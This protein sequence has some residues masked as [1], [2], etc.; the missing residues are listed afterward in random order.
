MT[1]IAGSG[2]ISRRHVSADPD[3]DPHQNVMDPEHWL[4]EMVSWALELKFPERELPASSIFQLTRPLSPPPPPSRFCVCLATKSTCPF[5]PTVFHLI[6]RLRKAE[7]ARRRPI[8]LLYNPWFF[9]PFCPIKWRT[10]SF[11][12]FLISV[13]NI[14]QYTNRFQQLQTGFE[15]L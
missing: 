2:S 9:A 7:V 12:L 5:P 1:K 3:P 6:H 15:I 10:K 8:H 4:H 13:Q 14:M 11:Q